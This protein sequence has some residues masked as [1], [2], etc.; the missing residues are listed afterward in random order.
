MLDAP[1]IT[2][3]P[4]ARHR[5]W[6]L[7]ALLPIIAG[8]LWLA[9]WPP[10]IHRAYVT[11]DGKYAVAATQIASDPGL[12]EVRRLDLR[13]GRT[14]RMPQLVTSTNYGHMRDD[15]WVTGTANEQ[16]FTSLSVI[17]LD[18]FSEEH[19]VDPNRWKLAPQFLDEQRLIGFDREGHLLIV[20]QETGLEQYFPLPAANANRWTMRVGRG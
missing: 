5:T 16:G 13:T 20:N 11:A 8:T 10:N 17:R 19:V 1:A 18:D 3:Q 4:S 14:I 2:A 7:L 6:L 15:R 9:S 12:W